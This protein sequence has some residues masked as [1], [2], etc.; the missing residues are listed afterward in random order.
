M[1][2]TL[3]RH[4]SL[5]RLEPVARHVDNASP[6]HEGEER[7]SG[8]AP[9]PR[10]P[11]GAKRGPKP[12]RG[13]LIL[14]PSQFFADAREDFR[15]PERR[16]MLAILS[17]AVE[18]VRKYRDAS[19]LDDRNLFQEAESWLMRPQAPHAEGFFSF[20]YV[21]EVL[22]FDPAAVRDQLRRQKKGR[23]TAG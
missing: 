22:G 3:V 16:L 1:R 7:A 6:P 20:E 19:K 10:K 4:A 9:A 2:S 23:G 17:D 11:P 15:H 13:R 18:C 12:A 21:C 14:L 5:A 8:L